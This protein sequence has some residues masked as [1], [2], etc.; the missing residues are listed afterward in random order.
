MAIVVVHTEVVA[1]GSEV[2]SDE[3]GVVA[4]AKVV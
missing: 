1:G 3:G 2:V 4:A